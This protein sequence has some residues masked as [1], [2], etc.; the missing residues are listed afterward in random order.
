[1]QWPQDVCTSPWLPPCAYVLSVVTI[2]LLFIA[3][4]IVHLN[5]FIPIF[6]G[7]YFVFLTN[8]TLVLESVTLILL[9]ISTVWAYIAS[10]SEGQGQ[11]QK[12]PL[13]VR[14]TLSFYYIIQPMSLIVVV[15]YW[16]SV[17]QFWDPYPVRFS[18]YWAHLLNWIVLFSSLFT[19]NIPWCLGCD[20][21]FEVTSV[22]DTVVIEKF[23]CFEVLQERN[24]VNGLF[25]DLFHLVHHPLLPPDW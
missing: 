7:F 25:F 18:S 4:Q 19:S 15:L 13:L 22:V 23:H 5:D 20:N 17:N 11:G 8:W 16:T 24:L 1:M 9:S 21:S 12:A 6:G 2:T 14:Y 3:M 10:K